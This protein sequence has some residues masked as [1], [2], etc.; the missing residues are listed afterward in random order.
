[1][2]P[3]SWSAVLAMVLASA[4]FSL[5]G[6]LL[7]RAAVDL[8]TIQLVFW[9]SVVILAI[10][11]P[12]LRRSGAG[13]RP[14]NARRMALRCASG[15]AAMLCFFW[16]IHGLPLGTATAVQYLSPVFTLLLAGPVLGER[17]GS[18]GF[19]LVGLAFVG[20]LLV[21]RPEV[22][23]GLLAG[24]AGLAGAA[25][26]GV[27]YVSVRLLRTTDP[28]SRIVWWFAVASVCATA[29]FALAEG[30]PTG[31]QWWLVLGIG[32]GATGGQFGM[33]LAYR[34]G[35]ATR[36]G[37]LSYA[38]VVFSAVAG[39]LVFGEGLSTWTVAGVAL[40]I[41]AGGALSAGVGRPRPPVSGNS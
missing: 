23:G 39:V 34:L 17:P 20:V 29:P 1:M 38:T 21:L 3:V 12:L 41:A 40:I 6:V 18:R 16:S 11:H 26:A 19:A 24:L 31:T 22:D 15:L 4:S 7:K 37:P 13:W 28:P 25:L 8:S 2:A 27:A 36:V 33:T 30:L 10:A 14:G 32:L 35:E 5:M 9:R